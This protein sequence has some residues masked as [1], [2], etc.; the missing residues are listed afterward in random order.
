MCRPTSR[1]DLSLSSGWSPNRSQALKN[2]DQT[3]ASHV[4]MCS[5]AFDIESWM[6]RGQ[7]SQILKISSKDLAT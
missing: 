4:F 1:R 2:H 7:G 6:V 5:D 3:I